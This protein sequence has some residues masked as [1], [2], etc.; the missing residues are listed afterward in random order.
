VQGSI[1]G[2]T[3]KQRLFVAEYLVD[4]NATQAAIRAGYSPK[5]AEFQASRLL[6]NVKVRAA[7]DQGLMSLAEQV[8][9][10]A[11][12]VLR[13]RARLAF[14]DPRKLFDASGNPLPIQELDDDT[15]AAI[16]GVEVV[17]LKGGE[18]IPG[19]L[20]YVRK[21]RLAGKDNSLAALEKYMGLNEKPVRF[22]LP[23][24]DRAEDCTTAQAAVLTAVAAG[25]LMLTEAKAMSDLIEAQRRAY[26]THDL[27]KRLEA[28][29][30][31]M[32][33]R[34]ARP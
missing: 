11:E 24:I 2:L 21:Y 22:V 18:A 28:I 32:N 30:E 14:F 9:I 10:S 13:E 12:R 16:A 3:D 4:R 33:K 34:E 6:S 29:E 8:G 23:Q 26:E 1:T 27:A 5:T 15:A 20:S 7:V 31:A 25:Q 19:A 17:E